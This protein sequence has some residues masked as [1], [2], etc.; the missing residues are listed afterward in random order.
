MNEINWNMVIAITGIMSLVMGI[1]GGLILSA[2]KSI[3]ITKDDHEKDIERINL[4]LY[5]G[6][7]ITVFVPREE[8]GDS[9][10]D[11]ER[12][13]DGSQRSICNKIE[14]LAESIECIKANQN[15]I[16]KEVSNLVG[17]FDQSIKQ[18][19]DLLYGKLLNSRPTKE[20]V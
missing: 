14:K 8:W 7:G 20:G 19:S 3:F 18:T 1:F 12:R 9:R 13:I 16:N 4:K 5:D 2:T 10:K 6:N 15:A 11:R 17:R